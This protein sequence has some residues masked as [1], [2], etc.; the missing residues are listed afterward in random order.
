MKSLYTVNK[1]IKEI[2]EYER[3]NPCKQPT[4]F[5]SSMTITYNQ[6]KKIKKDLEVL[7]ILKKYLYIVEKQ[8]PRTD[9]YFEILESDLDEMQDDEN[10]DDFHKVKRWLEKNKN[11]R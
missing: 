5:E 8:I 7:K 6:L 2:E 11:D 3:T 4:M 1:K 9:D 10:C